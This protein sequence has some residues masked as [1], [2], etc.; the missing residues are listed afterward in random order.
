M[1]SQTLQHA[2]D[3]LVSE[4]LLTLCHLEPDHFGDEVQLELEVL[5]CDPETLDVNPELV[6]L[7]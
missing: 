6:V 7:E 3:G 1:V 2:Y 4:L 5:V